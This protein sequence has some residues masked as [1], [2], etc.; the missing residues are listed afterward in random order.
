M[1]ALLLFLLTGAGGDRSLLAEIEGYDTEIAALN[2]EIDALE[3]RGADTRAL[4]A[5][6]RAE[7]AG[8]EAALAD[9]RDGVARRVGALYRLERRGLAR[10]LLDA[11]SPADLRRRVRY[12]LGVVRADDGRTREFR[13]AAE[14]RRASIEKVEADEALIT[15]LQADLRARREALEAERQ[16]RLALTREIRATPALTNRLTTERVASAQAM[17]SALTPA[18]PAADVQSFR[19]DRGRLP[20]PVTG[21]V[22]R[23]FGV[24]GDPATGSSESNLGVDYAAALGTPFRAVAD[25]VVARSGYVR[26]YGQVV[27]LQHGNY[28]TLYAHANGLRVAQGQSVQRGDVLGLVGNTGL[29]EDADARLHFEVRYNGTPQDPSEWLAR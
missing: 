19:N 6:H 14:A 15:G 3:R 12:L 28:T 4:H 7:L 21:R 10:L 20:S 29:A 5:S 11:E 27:V 8:A 25:G 9:R 17:S 26:G 13:A 16:R 18:L 24:Y 23:G 2:T 22:V 1:A